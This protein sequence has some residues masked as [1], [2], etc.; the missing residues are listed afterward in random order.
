MSGFVYMNY[1][2]MKTCILSCHCL[3]TVV[4]WSFFLV[5]YENRKN[6]EES[7]FFSFFIYPSATLCPLIGECLD[8]LT[9]DV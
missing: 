3:V 1:K 7:L 9:V 8:L 6:T 2:H 4:C 5:T